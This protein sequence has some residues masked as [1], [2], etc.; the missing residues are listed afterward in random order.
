MHV[1]NLL[2]SS[3]PN[4]FSSVLLAYTEKNEVKLTEMTVGGA[5][6]INL[7]NKRGSLL[8]RQKRQW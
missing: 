1:Q 2:N 5:G 6:K 4:L 7:K 8:R 3:K